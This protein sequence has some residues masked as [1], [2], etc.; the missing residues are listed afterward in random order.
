[1]EICSE[2]PKSTPELL[3]SLGYK[4]RTGNFKRAVSHLSEMGL[5]EMTI[6]TK[7][8]SKKQK[9]RLTNKGRQVLSGIKEG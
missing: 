7:P 4:N 1:M 8:R 3:Q 5:L 2:S 6:P 9:Y